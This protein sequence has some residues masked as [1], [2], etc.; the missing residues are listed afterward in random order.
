MELSQLYNMAKD[1]ASRKRD[2]DFGFDITEN[3]TITI[4]V[5]DDGSVYKASNGGTVSNGQLKITCS[6]TETVNAMIRAKRSKVD[7]MISLNVNTGEIVMPC[8]SCAEMIYQINHANAYTKVMNDVDS[9]IELNALLPNFNFSIGSKPNE[10]QPKSV[11]KPDIKPVQQAD[12][13]TVSESDD[14][15][16]GWG[17]DAVAT[18]PVNLHNQA[19]DYSKSLNAHNTIYSS[20]NYVSQ[21]LDVDSSTVSP[22]SVNSSSVSRV[23]GSQYFEEANPIP[24]RPTPKNTI[25]GNSNYYQSRYLNTNPNPLDASIQYS[26]MGSKS[27]NNTTFKRNNDITDRLRRDGLSESDKKD[28]NKQ[29]LYNAFTTDTVSN[30]NGSRVSDNSIE[31][32]ERQTYSKKELLKM[33][34]EKKKMAK[35]DAKLLEN[36][37]KKGMS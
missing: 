15:S 24:S 16:D 11:T 28:F 17:D 32:A 22:Q 20:S 35:K 37:K 19:D 23:Q 6:E 3:T 21:F 36:N 4:M 10:A 34:K 7:V 31:V 26:T 5:A 8:T 25:S 13:T 14:W 18:T 33:A 9:T 27:V 1:M 2:N 12:S 29:R 30:V